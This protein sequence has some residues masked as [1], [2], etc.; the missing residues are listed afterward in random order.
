MTSTPF[1]RSVIRSSGSIRAECRPSSTRQV[2]DSYLDLHRERVGEE[3]RTRP[4]PRPIQ[5]GRSKPS[6]S[7]S[8]SRIR[9]KS[10]IQEA[11]ALPD[12]Q[13]LWLEQQETEAYERY[14]GEIRRDR[15]G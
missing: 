15:L 14:D 7:S 4:D 6:P 1:A 11:C 13:A 8:P 5:G 2:V 3:H 12:A 9:L 10:V